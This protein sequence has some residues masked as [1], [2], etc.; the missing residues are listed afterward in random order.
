MEGAV[1]GTSRAAPWREVRWPILLMVVVSLIVAAVATRAGLPDSGVA[2]YRGAGVRPAGEF[3]VATLA[4]AIVL[5]AVVAAV[6]L[7]GFARGVPLR[8]RGPDDYQEVPPEIPVLWWEKVVALSL[9]LLL[10]AVLVTA[11]IASTRGHHPA[12]TPPPTAQARAQAPGGGAPS[13]TGS[14]HQAPTEGPG[15]A[16]EIGGLVALGIAA[17]AGLLVMIRRA[18]RPSAEPVPLLARRGAVADAVTLSIADL[19]READPRR[20]IVAAYARM[21]QV[22]GGA[23]VH[24]RPAETPLEYL[25]R[26]LLEARAPQTAVLDLTSL[27][28][29]AK[30]SRH[31]MSHANRDQALDALVQIEEHTPR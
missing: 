26:I 3:V 27:F 23:G 17:G 25:R 21:E 20:A 30:F 7:W 16:A 31:P 5:A 15:Q 13:G 28:Q 14:Q 24:R 29:E 8:R 12:D 2:Q 19:E 4:G 1:L 6:T 22:M 9:P 10:V 11:V 18:R